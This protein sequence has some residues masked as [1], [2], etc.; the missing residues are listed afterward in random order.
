MPRLCQGCSIDAGDGAIHIV[1]NVA[2]VAHNVAPT[3]MDNTAQ[4][5]H[6]AKHYPRTRPPE[7][8]NIFF[9]SLEPKA[10][11]RNAGWPGGQFPCFTIFIDP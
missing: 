10:E 9:A 3:V 5:L 7:Q 4:S 1:P 11:L 6:D 8:S 2:H